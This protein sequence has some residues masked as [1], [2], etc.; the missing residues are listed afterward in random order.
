MNVIYVH[1][2]KIIIISS[3]CIKISSVCMESTLSKSHSLTICKDGPFLLLLKAPSDGSCA[4]AHLP[5]SLYYR[6]L[7]V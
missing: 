1:C 7:S 4:I 3:V 6:V 2:G 5:I